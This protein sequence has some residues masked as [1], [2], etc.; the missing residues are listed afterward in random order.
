MTGRRSLARWVFTV[1]SESVRAAALVGPPRLM[2]TTLMFRPVGS[3]A[4]NLRRRSRT[5]SIAA[6]V[7]D[8]GEPPPAAGK[9]FRGTML[10]PGAPPIIGTRTVPAGQVLCEKR[11]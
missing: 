2:F 11:P 9:I 6:I 4:L 1:W 7:L 10:A 3:E 8:V 5:F